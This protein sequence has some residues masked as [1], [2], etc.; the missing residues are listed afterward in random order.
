MNKEFCF[1]K[2]VNELDPVDFDNFKNSKEEFYAVV[3]N[4]ETGKA[5]YIKI[6]DLKEEKQLEYI[7]A[8]G[9]MPYVSKIVEIDGKKYLD[10]GISDS[11]PIEKII[12]MGYDKIIVILTRP[13]SYRKKKGKLNISKIYYRGYPNLIKT[14]NNRYKL[15]KY[16]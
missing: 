2:I 12:N 16:K 10:G 11:I 4:V 1:D 3:T 9:S 8:S 5:E 6:D 13:Q 15:K 7:R 14:I